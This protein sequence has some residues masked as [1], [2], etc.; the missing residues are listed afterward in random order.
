[1]TA[2][3]NSGTSISRSVARSIRRVASRWAP[4]TANA[5]LV[6]SEGCIDNPATMN[7]PRV[8]LDS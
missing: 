8:P 5:I 2:A 3:G 7:H 1:M 6:S 4:H